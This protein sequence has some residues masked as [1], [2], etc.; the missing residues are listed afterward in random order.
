MRMG[1]KV[2]L[3]CGNPFTSID[4]TCRIA[5]RRRVEQRD[6]CVVGIV[7]GEGCCAVRQET[8]P[9]IRPIWVISA[10]V[11][12]FGDG[13]AGARRVFGY[14]G[15]R[16]RFTPLREKSCRFFATCRK[17]VS[18]CYRGKVAKRNPPLCKLLSD[19]DKHFSTSPAFRISES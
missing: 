12:I 1:S 16:Y 3:D 2:G 8:I 10:L 4:A 11:A 14:P 5:G 15:E 19:K 13:K 9:V 6:M 17:S 7:V 18:Y